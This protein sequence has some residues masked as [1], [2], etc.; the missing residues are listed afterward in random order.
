M[1]K[2]Y[3]WGGGTLLMRSDG[4]MCKSPK[5]PS[6]EA[7]PYM[8]KAKENSDAVCGANCKYHPQEL[9]ASTTFNKG[10]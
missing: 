3:Y 10:W 1:C 8:N 2:Y 4:P 7:C 9:K 6:N 5:K